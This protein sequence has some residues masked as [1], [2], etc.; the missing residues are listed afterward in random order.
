MRAATPMPFLRHS[1]SLSIDYLTGNRALSL[2]RLLVLVAAFALLTGCVTRHTSAPQLV[3]AG[4]RLEKTRYQGELVASD[5]KKIRFTVWQP[6][7]KKDQRAPLILHAHG[8]ALTRMNSTMDIYAK[9]LIAGKTALRAWEQGYWVISIDQRGH[10]ASQGTVGLLEWD[11]EVADVSLIIDWA[12]KNLALAERDGDPLIGMVG[13]SYGGGIQLLASVNDPRIDAIVPLTT[14]YD[15]EDALIPQGVPKSEWLLV[16]G[17]AG[18]MFNPWHMDHGM[19]VQVAKE[20]LF[21]DTQPALRQKLARNSLAYHCD[22]GNYPHADALVIQGFRDVLFPM[23]HAVGM[24]DC[25]RKAG[26]DV[27]VIGVEHGHLSPTA[28]ISPRVPVWHVDPVVICDGR[29]L[30]LQTMMINWFDMKLRGKKI[31][32]T[33]VPHWCMTGERAVDAVKDFP[34]PMVVPVRH[35][36]VGSG[37]AGLVE[38]AAR[39]LES[40]KNWFVPNRMPADWSTPRDG[41]LRPARV[42]LLQIAGPT[43]IVG[44]PVL[45]VTVDEAD[46]MNPVLFVRLAAWTPGKGNYRVLSQQVTPLRGKGAQRVEINGVRAKLQKGEVL[47]LLVNGYSNQFRL[48]GSGWGTDAGISGTIALPL[49]GAMR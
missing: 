45:E 47:G 36:H 8:F 18:Y 11:K 33:A 16:L 25:F 20:V 27:R 17:V 30:D 49:A 13:E 14:W 12:Q 38:W 35:V 2:R 10:G 21:D 7:L 29:R 23:N 46:R 48:T 26:K 28:Q 4:G 22:G 3:D 44:N 41:W 1:V 6:A 37:S 31:V 43:W 32:D 24:R 40:A 5:G 39:P 34:P 19:T 15:I 42:P 9:L